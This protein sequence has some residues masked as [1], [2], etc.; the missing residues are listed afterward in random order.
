MLLNFLDDQNMETVMKQLDQQYAPLNL[1]AMISRHGTE[2]QATNARDAEL[3][4]RERLCRALSMFEVVMQRIKSFLIS[5]KVTFNSILKYTNNL[6]KY[7]NNILKFTNNMKYA[8]N[9]LKYACMYYIYLLFQ[10]IIYT[11]KLYILRKYISN[12]CVTYLLD[13]AG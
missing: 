4:T 12:H 2:N 5:D 9:V 11:K 10:C 6:L 1:V 7:T 8:N 13:M 3:L